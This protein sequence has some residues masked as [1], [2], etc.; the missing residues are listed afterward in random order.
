MMGYDDPLTLVTRREVLLDIANLLIGACL[1]GI[2][3]QFD[4]ELTFGAPSLLAENTP[5]DRLLNTDSLEWSH[6]LLVEV[7]F[8]L[9]QGAFSSH[10]VIFLPEQSIEAM[11]ESLDQLMAAL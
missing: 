10:L 7:N 3:R 4:I 1:G 6:A 2:C 11:R 9:E 8:S 5:A